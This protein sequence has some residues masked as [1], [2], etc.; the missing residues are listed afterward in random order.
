MMDFVQRDSPRP[1]GIFTVSAPSVGFA[2]PLP[3]ARPCERDAGSAGG[4]ELALG[5]ERS[6]AQPTGDW[7][8]RL[9]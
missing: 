9:A 1:A 7:Y 6:L 3:E 4:L 5:L 8:E 2:G